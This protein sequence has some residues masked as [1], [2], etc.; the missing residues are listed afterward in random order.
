[1]KVNKFITGFLFVIASLF[2]GSSV[3]Y[4]CN[5]CMCEYG[6]SQPQSE[7]VA[8]DYLYDYN[9]NHWVRVNTYADRLSCRQASRLV[10]R[11]R[12][13]GFNVRYYG[14]WDCPTRIVYGVFHDA[15]YVGGFNYY[16]HWASH[17]YAFHHSGVKVYFHY[18][19]YHNG[20]HHYHGYAT[21][22]VAK[23]YY[24]SYATTKYKK[25][26]KNHYK[27]VPV[28]HKNKNKVTYNKR[29]YKSNKKKF[30][31]NY[32]SNRNAYKSN[33]NANSG[34]YKRGKQSNGMR[35]H[36]NK[37]GRGSMRANKGSRGSNRGK[38]SNRAIRNSGKKSKHR[39]QRRIS[40]N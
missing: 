39:K 28:Y 34:K 5:D 37:G 26:K 4:A 31:R 36:H 32:K 15:F 1:M 23:S 3:A 16:N 29:S 22:Y 21:H 24:K 10:V 9:T 40:R 18:N 38:Y 12:A 25:W 33:R 6:E 11:L 7:I 20:R 2:V 14:N 13:S 27:S 19:A 35:S 30:A 17:H 8:Y